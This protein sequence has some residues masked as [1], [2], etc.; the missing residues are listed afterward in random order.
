MRTVMRTPLILALLLP[1]IVDSYAEPE[2]DTL[3]W[4]RLFEKEDFSFTAY[5]PQIDS[6][7]DYKRLE[8]RLA[9]EFTPTGSDASTFSALTIKASTKTDFSA[10][11]VTIRN[12]KI[13]EVSF[14]N[15]GKANEKKYRAAIKERIH[16][17]DWVVSLDR[18]LAGM[19][20][21]EGSQREVKV[22]TEAPPIYYSDRDAVLVQFMGQPATEPIAGTKLRFVVNSNWTMIGMEG[23]LG[24]YLLLDDGW[25]WAENPA[26]GPWKAIDKLPDEFQLLPNDENWED[27]RKHVPGTK[28]V[29]VPHVFVSLR[30]AEL[31]ETGG[32]PELEKIEGTGVSWVKNTDSDLFFFDA[33]KH[34]YYLAA[35]RWFKASA[36]TERW[37]F[38]DTPPADFAKIPSEHPRGEVLVSVPGT[39]AAEEAVV[40]AS[41]PRK[42]S[43]KREGTTIEVTYDGDPEFE[44]IEGTGGV[45]YALNTPNDVLRYES[46]F[47]CVSDGVWFEAGA[48]TG[49]WVLCEKVPAAIYTIPADHC[50]HYVVYV[51]VYDSDEDEVVYGY[52]DGY[53][54]SYIWRGR[55]WFGYG[56][57]WGFRRGLAWKRWYHWRHRPTHYAWGCASRYSMV[58]SGWVRGATLYG[59]YGGVGRAPA[60]RPKQKTYAR[61][62]AAYGPRD[63]RIAHEAF[64]PATIGYAGRSVKSR[65]ATSVYGAWGANRVQARDDAW[66]RKTGQEARARAAKTTGARVAPGKKNNVYVGKDGGVY[67]HTTQGWS[68]RTDSGGWRAV[69]DPRPKPKQP[70]AR[71]ANRPSQQQVNRSLQ[72]SQG[73]RNRG[74]TRSRAY[75]QSRP[76]TSYRSSASRSR[77]RSGGGRRGGGGRRR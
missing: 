32:E 16:G 65:K 22:S 23:E 11:T 62:V 51:H 69:T 8:F 46:R 53:Y 2:V 64:S 54:G 19:K 36:L 60:Y 24:A 48:V 31:I 28:I 6:W 33:D 44:E 26:K 55:C 9:L 17:K 41:I 5:Q 47:Y 3:G 42:A 72:R 77:A 74:Y 38:V 15:A 37:S 45:A 1:L 59:P 29:N 13:A 73:S 25:I 35:G 76:R 27:V 63:G 49:P 66:A 39:D 58:R 40:Q 52:T 61:G 14:P 7:K 56:A 70:T 68:R 34:W 12:M 67:K 71:P 75:H 57:W 4:P 50:M 30:P 43:V 20:Q 21:A 10:R 18:M